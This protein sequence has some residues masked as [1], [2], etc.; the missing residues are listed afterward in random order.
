MHPEVFKV[1]DVTHSYISS[2]ASHDTLNTTFM[3]IKVNSEVC[4]SRNRTFDEISHFHI[5]SDIVGSKRQSQLQQKLNST[6]LDPMHI[7]K[8]P[9]IINELVLGIVFSAN[10]F[11]PIFKKKL[12][13][14][15]E[16]AFIKNAI[17]F[18]MYPL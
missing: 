2:F 7:G 14:T 8:G 12:I 9:C 5:Y 18:L 4:I 1:S 15:F 3:Q 17:S 11:F 10:V 13:I 6:Q 16:V